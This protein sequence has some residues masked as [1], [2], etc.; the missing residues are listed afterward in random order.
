MENALSLITPQRFDLMAKVI[1]ARYRTLGLKTKYHEQLYRTHIKVFNNGLEEAK[2]NVDDFVR[3]FD[4]LI[5]SIQRD[6]FKASGVVPVG[7]GNVCINGAHR[8]ST[9]TVLGVPI[10]VLRQPKKADVYDATWFLRRKKFLS[11]GLPGHYADR[12]ALEY[13]RLKPEVRIITV[14]PRADPALD[15]KLRQLLGAAGYVQYETQFTLKGPG[16]CNLIKEL[17]HGEKWVGSE[18]NGWSGAK[19][20]EKQ[21]QGPH[22]VRVFVFHPNDASDVAMKALKERLRAIWKIDKSSLHIN[23]TPVETRRI[24]SCVL[25]SNSIHYLNHAPTTLSKVNSELLTM[26]QLAMNR[27]TVEQRESVAVDS[28]FVMGVYGLRDA[29]DVDFIPS[30]HTTPETLATLSS[31][32]QIDCHDKEFVKYWSGGSLDDLIYNPANHFYL[33][34]IKF[35]TLDVL[36]TFKQKRNEKPKDI[37]DLALIAKVGR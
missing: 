7:N 28:S 22:P 1:Y 5:D 25:N 6:G 15:G 14:Y 35:V 29:R 17:Y 33:H 20:K 12:M 8:I 4:Q 3:V 18:K 13:C 26:L 31:S 37:N 34:G 19:A 21:C 11:T 27:L 30:T 9:C 16:L 32:K 2:R 23:D 36:K 10:H 24:A